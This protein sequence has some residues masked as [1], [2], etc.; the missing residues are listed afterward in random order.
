[1][2][3]NGNPYITYFVTI[4]PRGPGLVTTSVVMSNPTFVTAESF[5]LSVIFC[6]YPPGLI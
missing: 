6:L 2:W 5:K 4:S 1:M 3:Q